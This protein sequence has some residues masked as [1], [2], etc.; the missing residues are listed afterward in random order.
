MTVDDTLDELAAELTATDS[1]PVDR[2][3]NRW[4]GEAE[5]VAGDL[6][7]SDLPDEVVV[8]RLGHVESL[9]SN[10]DETGSPEADEHVARAKSLTD[11]AL[12]ALDAA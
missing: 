9:L 1:Y 12:A 11:D 10:V 8:E 6:A 3:A 5:A 2:T 4:L 7:A